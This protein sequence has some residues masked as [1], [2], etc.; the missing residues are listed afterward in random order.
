[1]VAPRIG[2]TGT[3]DGFGRREPWR[4]FNHLIASRV[5]FFGSTSAIFSHE[6]EIEHFHAVRHAAATADKN[7][8]RL[9]VAMNQSQPM[10]LGQRIANLRENVNYAANIFLC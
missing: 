1:K 9:D 4:A 10:R 7:I 3:P 5:C 8:C 6:T 2:W